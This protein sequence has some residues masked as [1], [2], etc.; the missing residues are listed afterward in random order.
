MAARL[1]SEEDDAEASNCSK[2]NPP[3]R[4]LPW[5]LLAPA[6]RKIRPRPMAIK[7][8]KLRFRFSNKEA[9]C[10]P[11]PSPSTPSQAQTYHAERVHVCGAE[12]LEAGAM[13]FSESGRGRW[14]RSWPCG[15]HRL[16]ELARLSEGQNP[17]SGEQLVRHRTGQVYTNSDGRSSAGRASGRLDATSQRPSLFL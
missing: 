17:H 16:T 1:E 7:S 3:K 12:L 10:S 8:H 4:S 9:L 13:R 11:S 2:T 15:S 5:F 14:P 6:S